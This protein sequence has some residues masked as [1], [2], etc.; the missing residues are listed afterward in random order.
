M[1]NAWGWAVVTLLRLCG[2]NTKETTEA[3]RPLSSGVY[4]YL[5]FTTSKPSVF[6]LINRVGQ[7]CRDGFL[8]IFHS[9]NNRL[10]F[11]LISF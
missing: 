1:L 9:T 8:N 11:K 6:H 7:S 4:K 3:N 10:L 5:V 2:K